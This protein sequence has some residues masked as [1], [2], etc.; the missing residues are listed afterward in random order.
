MSQTRPRV[1]VR[2]HLDFL[3]LRLT[4]MS[5]TIATFHF[6]HILTAYHV[7]CIIRPIL[8]LS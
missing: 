8:I 2:M 5:Q 7:G 1:G 4:T 3:H 6:N